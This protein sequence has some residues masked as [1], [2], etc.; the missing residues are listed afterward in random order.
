MARSRA[1]TPR[2]PIRRHQ[3]AAVAGPRRP[4]ALDGLVRDGDGVLLLGLEELGEEPWAVLRASR[5]ELIRAYDA[6]AAVAVIAGGAAQVVLTDVTRGPELIDA[7]CER[8]ELAA[9]PR[10]GC[11][12][13]HPPP[14]PPRAPRPRARGRGGPPLA[15]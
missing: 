14:H 5:L 2:Q 4:S 12:R 8:P 1:S 10:L 11:A 13:P 15:P 9:G 3:P 7:V 6:T